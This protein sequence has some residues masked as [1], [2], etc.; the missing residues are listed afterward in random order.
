MNILV[1]GSNGQLGS[2]IKN[3]AANYANFSF[4]FMDLPALDI[5]N[6]SQLDVFFKDKNINTVINCAA[7]TAVDKA[8][9]DADIAEKV[10]ATGVLNLV[11]AVAKVYGKLIHISTDYVFDGNHFLPYKESDPVSPT[12]VYGETKRA[13][14]LAVINSDIDSIVIRTSWL[15]SSYGNNFVKTMLRLGNEKEDLGVI[16]DQVG[17]PTY[18]RDLAKTCLEILCKDSS[19]DISEN[20]SLYHYSNEGVASWYDFAI[21]I[22]EL[23]GKNCK[24]NPI[25][26]KDYP[27]LAKRPQYSVLNKSKIKTDFKIEIPYWRD[28][29]KDCIEKIKN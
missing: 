25:Q 9:K 18:A 10:N 22:M 21:S 2:E 19:V 3:L 1:T 17:T 14:E 20:G 29:L 16:F 24:V 7:Y 4:F 11:N 23:G 8:E 13:G 28:S 6:S 27:T 15:Y 12:G 26:T 5:C